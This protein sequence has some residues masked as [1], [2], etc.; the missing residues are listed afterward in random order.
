M[1]G[2]PTFKFRGGT[3]VVFDG[4]GRVQYAIA[5]PIDDPDRLQ[6]QR[7]FQLD[8]MMRGAGSA[9]VDPSVPSIDLAA[10][11]RGY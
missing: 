10:L 1:A 5:K 8:L 7:D 3:T 9:Y 11:H 2:S 4:Q 6:R